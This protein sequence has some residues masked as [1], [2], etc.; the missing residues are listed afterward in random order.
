MK[1]IRLLLFF[2][3]SYSLLFIGSS[4]IAIGQTLDVDS[5]Q[6]D[7]IVKTKYN[8]ADFAGSYVAMG[9]VSCYCK[10][11]IKTVLNLNKLNEKHN[12]SDVKVVGIYVDETTDENKLR[13]FVYEHHIS[14]ALYMHNDE[15][16]RKYNVI[17]IPTI[18]I[19]DKTGK[20]I[21][22]YFGH[23][24]EKVFEKDFVELHK[25]YSVVN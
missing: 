2:L 25:K 14:Y 12:G 19:F 24:Q 6:K 20:M 13:K 22:T 16:T 4:S 5:N 7:V 11:C 17:Y 15:I 10:Q 1:R 9:F 3:F 18:L 23:R 8:P 21:K